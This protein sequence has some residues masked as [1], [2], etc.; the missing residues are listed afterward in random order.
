MNAQNYIK[1]QEC[2]CRKIFGQLSQII[3]GKLQRVIP[4][5]GKSEVSLRIENSGLEANLNRCRHLESE[6]SIFMYSLSVISL[7]NLIPTFL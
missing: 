3:S 6:S 2:T 1:K 4:S 5:S 7:I